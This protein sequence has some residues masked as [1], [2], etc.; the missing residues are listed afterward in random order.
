MAD[1]KVTALRAEEVDEALV[2]A[3]LIDPSLGI[4][5]WRAD[6]TAVSASGGRESIVLA[7]QGDGPLCGLAWYRLDDFGSDRPTLQL[8]KLVAFD[9]TQPGRIAAALVSEILAR[10]RDQGCAAV[11]IEAGL[12]DPSRVLDLAMAGGFCRLHSVF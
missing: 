6:A 5:A 10:A 7:R 4:D 9:L 2:L 12:T 11:R 3:Q 1:L 8:L